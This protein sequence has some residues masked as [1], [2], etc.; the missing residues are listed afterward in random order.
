M[1][2]ALGNIF[3]GYLF[4]FFDFYIMIDLLMDPI[5]YFLIYTGCAR[6]VGAY[7]NAKKAM[8]V[9]MIGVFVSL[10][11]VF[12]NLSDS[13]LPFGWSIYESMLSILKLVIAF[14]LFLVLMEVAKI[15]GN[16]ALHNR[17]QTTFKYFVTIHF[18]ILTV[19]SFSMNVSGDGWVALTVILIIA[20]VLMDI[21]FLLLI[22]AFRRVSPDNH[23]ISYSV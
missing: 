5:G 9:A 6:I 13:A 16:V 23:R 11:T 18:A 17:A 19:M 2:K 21:L 4:I 8:T 7:P 12:I 3:W 20:G 22:R 14:Y 1:N 10:P 15:F